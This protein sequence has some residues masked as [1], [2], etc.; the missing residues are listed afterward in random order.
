[1]TGTAWDYLEADINTNYKTAADMTLSVDNRIQLHV[2]PTVEKYQDLNFR[3]T[4]SLGD[5][6]LVDIYT[7]DAIYHDRNTGAETRYVPVGKMLVLPSKDK[8]IKVYGRIMHPDAGFRAQP[9][10]INSWKDQK[11]GKVET[12]IHM[13]YLMGHTDIDTCVSWQVTSS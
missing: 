10:F 8:G 2:L 7:Y 5:G 13:N 11:T 6:T 12:E 3:R 1:L 4:L 9:R